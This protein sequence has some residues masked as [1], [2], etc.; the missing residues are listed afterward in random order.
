MRA[1]ND[2]LV[3]IFFGLN[4]HKKKIL[5][6]RKISI[7]IGNDARCSIL[8]TW[9]TSLV[10]EPCILKFIRFFIQIYKWFTNLTGNERPS[11]D[12]GTRVGGVFRK[13]AGTYALSTL[14][15][16]YPIVPKLT[17]FLHH[18][19]PKLLVEDWNLV[20]NKNSD[21]MTNFCHFFC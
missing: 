6:L 5:C 14:W 3:I 18:L 21:H 1:R 19:C 9:N 15:G 17:R 4:S 13:P 8:Y 20:H 7:Y 16:W 2:N 12:R 11:I 10:G